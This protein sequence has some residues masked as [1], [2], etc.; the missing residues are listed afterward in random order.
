VLHLDTYLLSTWNYR[1]LTTPMPFAYVAHLRTFI[2]L[3]L[4]LLAPLFCAYTG[5]LAPV[6]TIPI[7]LLF[8]GMDSISSEIE[9]PFGHDWN[10]LPLDSITAQL[11]SDFVEVSQLS[12]P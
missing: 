5:W 4:L 11:A 7:V 12:F 8:L 9:N 1:I 10:D 2:L 6:A 3:W